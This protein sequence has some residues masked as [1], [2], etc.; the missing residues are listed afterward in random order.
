MNQELP[1]VNIGANAQ[2]ERKI[3]QCCEVITTISEPMRLRKWSFKFMT[4]LIESRPS[5]QVI[6]MELDKGLVR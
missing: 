3:S 2:R 1:Q 6:S 4:A 5:S